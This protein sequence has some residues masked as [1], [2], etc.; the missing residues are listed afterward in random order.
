MCQKKNPHTCNQFRSP[1]FP[2]FAQERF[3][4]QVL[5]EN[6]ELRSLLL[7]KEG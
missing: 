4:A 1:L 7:A 2:F 3:N 6:E 5:E